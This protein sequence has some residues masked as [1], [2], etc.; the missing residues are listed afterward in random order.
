MD[1]RSTVAESLAGGGRVS[2][3][4]LENV[5]FQKLIL[6]LVFFFFFNNFLL[7]FSLVFSSPEKIFGWV[8]IFFGGGGAYTLS[9]VTTDRDWL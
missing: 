3:K 9:S 4:S 8:R 5:N 1:D 2:K 7:V 6:T